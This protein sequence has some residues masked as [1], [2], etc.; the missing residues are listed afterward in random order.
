MVK[1]NNK[2]IFITMPKDLVEELEVNTKQCDTTI[3][4]FITSIVKLQYG[5]METDEAMLYINMLS[6]EYSKKEAD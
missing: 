4:K 1:D 5:H 6:K 2:R 3:S